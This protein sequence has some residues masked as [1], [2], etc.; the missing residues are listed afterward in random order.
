MSTNVAPIETPV[1]RKGARS[2][3]EAR[4]LDSE[5]CEKLGL[6]SRSDRAGKG[7]IL[8]PYER[9]GA[10][11]Y[12]KVRKIEPKGFY[13]EPGGTESLFWREDALLD[14]ALAEEPLLIT[15]GEFDAIAAIQAGFWRTVSV[16]DGAPA[17]KLLDA[18]EHAQRYTFVEVALDRLEPIKEII[19]AAD[20]DGPGA[21]LLSDLTTLLGPARCK[22]IKYP[23]GCKDLND[24]LAKYGVEGVRACIEKSKWVRVVGVHKL[25]DMPPLP[26]I[27]IW[28]P[29]VHAPVDDLLPICPGHLSVWTG[30]PGHGKS[31]L[32]NAIAW[33]I[34]DRDR[35]RIAHG[36][37]EATPQREYLNAAVAFHAG[38]KYIDVGQQERDEIA[39]WVNDQ[40]TFLVS[41]GYVGPGQEEFFDADLDWF[42]EAARTAVVRD[43]CRIVILDP[44]SQIEHA[45]TNA[46]P[47]TTYVQR[48]IRR[49]KTFART[50]D[51]HVA[52]IAHP[53]KQRKLDDGSYAMPEGYE[54]SG[55]A[56]WFNGVDLGVTVHRHAPLIPEEREARDKSGKV[57]M[58]RGRPVMEST[59]EW[60]PDPA[61][62]RVLIR[63]W[64][65][66]VHS[67][68]GKPG[69]A[70][71]SFD[72]NTGRYG[73]A[74]H[75]EERTYP[76]QY[77]D[78]HRD[79]DD[80]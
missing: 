45:R 58:E 11:V 14:A 29:N 41:D 6:T 66:K 13:R 71:A 73:P 68:M 32:L 2:W 9:A 12:T 30:I 53:T 52:I 55:S 23:D 72:S 5:L 28:R 47:E 35:I 74:E 8:I 46:E 49:G 1:L 76:K 38:R 3:L 4:G 43:G 54:I 22:F 44:W 16:P 79:G 60:V 50:F 18:G 48:S 69:D 7:E 40:I 26:P 75:W 78:M 77:P 34:A 27:E 33:S 80:G 20:A 70:Y 57:I 59:G 64:K 21:A 63:A 15:E 42:F 39:R 10:L 67:V 17:K 24:V 51:V 56:H 61:S 62:T 31:A 36:T 19:I 37:F 65:K 25:F